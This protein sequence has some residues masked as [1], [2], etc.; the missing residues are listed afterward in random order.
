[1]K[2][3]ELY[4]VYKGAKGDP[5]NYR[6]YVIVSSQARVVV[7]HSLLIEMFSDRGVGTMI[8]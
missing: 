3:G 5:K 1:L 4:R 7:P 8:L 6:V 2:R